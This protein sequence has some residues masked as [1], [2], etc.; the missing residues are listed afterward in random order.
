MLLSISGFTFIAVLK[1]GRN[2]LRDFQR[3][4]TSSWAIFSLI[5]SE[6]I[7]M[8]YYCTAALSKGKPRPLSFSE[9]RERGEWAGK[10]NRWIPHPV[11]VLFN[12]DICKWGMAPGAAFVCVSSV[13]KLVI[14]GVCA[15]THTRILMSLACRLIEIWTWIIHAWLMSLGNLLTMNSRR[16][17]LD[18]K[19]VIW[20]CF[21]CCWGEKCSLLCLGFLC[22]YTHI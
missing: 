14:S 4:Q 15:H 20:V 17:D 2:V 5:W 13:L 9:I 22:K 10:W 19:C 11:W 3:L 8:L 12:I 1:R 16:V 18:V 21:N 6:N 7:V